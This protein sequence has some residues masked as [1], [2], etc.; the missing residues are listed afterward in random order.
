MVELFGGVMT[1]TTI[2]SDLPGN[3]EESASA[4]CGSEGPL[5]RFDAEALGLRIQEHAAVIAQATCDLLLMVEEFDRRGALAWFHG[6]KT[7]AHW[8]SWACSM[9]PGAAR[10]HVRVA[11]ALPRMP[12]TLDLFKAGRLS[13]SKV[14]EM[15]RV[16]DV[17]DEKRLVDLALEMTASQLARTIQAF[18]QIDGTAIAQE[19]R[20][21]VR[22]ST[23]EDGMV[24]L[25]AVLPADVGGEVTTALE[26]ALERDGTDAP[27]GA[28]L[29]GIDASERARVG[30][31]EP[32]PPLEYRRADALVDLARTY[33]DAAPA[34][35]TGEDRH[36]VVVE[37][38]GAVLEG[39]AEPE[40]ALRDGACGDAVDAD[41]TADADRTA[42]A[43]DRDTDDSGDPSPRCHVRGGPPLEAATALRLMCTGRT[44]AVVRDASGDVLHLGQAKRLASPAQRRALRI[45]DRSCR[46]PGCHQRRHLDAHHLVPWQQGG[47]TDIDNLVLLCR[48]HHVIVHEGGLRVVRTGEVRG[49]GAPV[50]DVIDSEGHPVTV[51]WPAM[52]EQVHVEHRARGARAAQP[53]LEHE[54]RRAARRGR[55]EEP[56]WEQAYT[57]EPDRIFPTSA[58][59]GF[60]LQACVTA[61][62][63][64]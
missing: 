64:P 58:G 18:R 63:S 51:S 54:P 28:D 60:S 55:G 1:A 8:L 42:D 31:S 36:L 45:R 22:W 49:D 30:Q 19:A 4:D 6:L 40:V 25:R 33:L 59:A 48:R 47:A 5:A 7:V 23:R 10:E 62:C 39:G 21:E 27:A 17:V 61:L 24:E 37:V 16:I 14:R 32:P 50:I 56:G 12:R 53:G 38:S 29:A 13:Y 43:D 35:R 3:R 9:S 52:F 11:R 20:R 2:R 44:L 34:D 15:S 41:N 57:G 26:L 46:F